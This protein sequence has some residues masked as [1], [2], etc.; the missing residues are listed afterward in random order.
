MKTLFTLLLSASLAFGQS[1]GDYLFQKKGPV[2]GYL[3]IYVTPQNGKLLGWSSGNLVNINPPNSA[4]WGSINGTLSDQTDLNAE[5]FSGPVLPRTIAAI[6]SDRSSSLIPFRLTQWVSGDSYAPNLSDQLDA[7]V[8]IKVGSGGMDLASYGGLGTAGGPTAGDFTRS[9]SG[10]FW[11]LN[12]AAQGIQYGQTANGPEMRKVS[13]FYSTESGLTGSWYAQSSTAGGAWTDIPGATSGAPISTNTGSGIGAAVF[14][15]DFGTTANRRIR[16][17]RSTGTVKLLGMCYTDITPSGSAAWKGGTEVF[18]FSFSG[19]HVAE[20]SACPQAIFNVI[21]QTLKPHFGTFKADDNA[22]QMASLSTYISKCNT[23]WPMDWVIVSSHPVNGDSSNNLSAADVVI[24]DYAIANRYTFVNARKLLPDYATMV[25]LGMLNGDN[26]HLSATGNAYENAA[27]VRALSAVLK[28]IYMLEGNQNLTVHKGPR[29]WKD[30]VN[31]DLT[32]GATKTDWLGAY[33]RENSGNLPSRIFGATSYPDI[34][35]IFTVGG[36]QYGRLWLTNGNS[37]FA[38]GTDGFGISAA[39]PSRTPSGT[40]EVYGGN[41]TSTPTISLSGSGS[42][43][44]D[45]LEVRSGATTSAAGT[46]LAGINSA[47][48]ADFV[49]LTVGGSTISGPN[50]GDQNTIVGITG[51]AAQ[52]NTA[53]TGDDFA[54]L[55]A[56]NTF[57][58]T[59]RFDSNTVQFLDNSFNVSG[60]TVVNFRNTFG[61]ASL[62]GTETL[63]NKTLTSPTLTTPILGT[64]ASGNFGSGTFTW[65]TFNQSTTG[66]AATVTTNANLTGA[67]TSVGN[68]TS[69]GSFSSATLRASLTDESG[70]GVAIFDGGSFNGTTITANTQLIAPG[71]SMSTTGIAFGTGGLFESGG[72]V[73]MTRS[74]IARWRSSGTSLA[75]PGTSSIGFSATTATTEPDT[76]FTRAGAGVFGAPSMSITGTLTVNALPVPAVLSTITAIN[77]KTTGTTNLYTVPTGKTA[78]VTAINIRC[79]AASAITIGPTIGVGVAAG[80]DDIMMPQ[81]NTITATT[82]SFNWPIIGRSVIAPAAAVIKL[83]LDTAATGTSQTLEIDVIGYTY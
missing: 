29:F 53:L 21:L 24:R 25:S 59:S 35:T 40:L 52:F 39:K 66:N 70:T 4:T 44:A 64:P 22:S 8:A 15:Y 72:V 18:D 33:S 81:T 1:A 20:A 76:A 17:Y 78:V 26:Y 11:N 3:P 49:N 36:A 77:G 65:P 73:T 41:A 51:T 27:I 6:Q 5:L 14:T 37:M 23:A 83:G 57:T 68:A 56:S 30:F 50:T 42:Q 19:R 9:P 71:G 34:S 48:G 82:Q 13:I 2:S 38:G 58:G 80:E 7:Q 69:L 32:V 16:F 45:F 54:T 61:L 55:A 31:V 74:N 75:V 63:T 47:G 62:T 46:R 28:P 60:S 67:I 43:T 10:T 79:S 12:S